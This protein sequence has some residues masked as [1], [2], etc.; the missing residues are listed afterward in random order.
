VF[1]Y[2]Y[3]HPQTAR[4]VSARVLWHIASCQHCQKE[5]EW[6]KNQL[7]V[8]AGNT[9][10]K[11]DRRG[12]AITALLRLHLTLVGKVV[13]CSTVK[14]F[15]PSLANPIL[16]IARPTPITAHLDKC[17]ACSDDV[18][19]LINYHLTHTQLC[20]LASLMAEKPPENGAKCSMAQATALSVAQFNLD[21]ADP[22]VLRHL[23][24]CPRCRDLIH[25]HRKSARIELEKANIS[26]DNAICQEL[27]SM[28]I[29]DYC[30]PY[31]IDP[32]GN[33]PIQ[34]N[35]SIAEHL[36]SC[37]K[38]LSKIQQLHTAVYAIIERPDSEIATCFTLKNVFDT[39]SEIDSTDIDSEQA[40]SVQMLGREASTEAENTDT[41]SG[42]DMRA[43]ERG[44]SVGKLI[45]FMKPVVAAA[46]V[47]LLVWALFLNTSEV[48]ALE[49]SQIY[50]ALQEVKSVCV[51]SFVPNKAE[52]TQTAWV[53]QTLNVRLQIDK[54]QAVLFDMRSKIRKI[55]DLT[56]NS[57]R[58]S[59]M[60][61]ELL[62]KVRG[63]IAGSLGLLPFPEIKF[64]P[65]G[66]RWNRVDNQNV[67]TTVDGTEVYDLIWKQRYGD[68][69]LF[70]KWRVFVDV[71]T[72]LPKRTET[73]SKPESQK[74]FTLSSFSTVAYPSDRV[75]E[76][77]ISST[78]N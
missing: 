27:S 32:A 52:P 44:D 61:D 46:A 72:N 7:A 69:G 40:V 1:Y 45:G 47:L 21:E 35:E 51:R 39:V 59:T 53:S 8:T 55:K 54:R 15:L 38:C 62:S 57:I 16:Q 42:K 41:A 70:R 33:Q 13:K 49:F 4:R 5:I 10:T 24:L 56:D 22:E 26:G 18:K 77:M 73:Y 43:L 66:A 11:Q 68:T 78:F 2:D 65:D 60:T 31:G 19:T 28:D 74:E 48:R 36:R 67:D 20:R 14:P 34:C 25:Q 17:Q 50:N 29:L 9:T 37:P 64:L 6:L 58:T 30:V 75:I 63:N 71:N 3:L 23:C 12:S 76:S